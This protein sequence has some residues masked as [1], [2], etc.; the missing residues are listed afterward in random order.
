MPVSDNASLRCARINRPSGSV[1]DQIQH[2]DLK[3]YSSR[4]PPSTLRET[5]HYPN[6]CQSMES[7][8]RLIGFRIVWFGL[9]EIRSVAPELV[10]QF[11]KWLNLDH[12][13]TLS[14]LC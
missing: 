7:S 6:P 3:F 5:R 12:L 4:P 13:T 10:D 14:L 9:R 11:L 8:C 1:L 2:R